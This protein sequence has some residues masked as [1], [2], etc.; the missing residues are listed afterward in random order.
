[1]TTPYPVP[2]PPSRGFWTKRTFS[3]GR[4]YGALIPN[5]KRHGV[6][7]LAELEYG[8][9]HLSLVA[10][11][12]RV[13]SF[14]FYR[15]CVECRLRTAAPRGMKL[16]IE[17]P[18][19]FAPHDGVPIDPEFDARMVVWAPA[20]V[21]RAVLE[22]PVRSQLL[23]MGT[24]FQGLY[25]EDGYVDLVWREPL[26]KPDQTLPGEGELQITTLIAKRLRDV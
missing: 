4:R 14:M 24:T 1:M 13:Y 16:S 2:P 8:G 15:K 5:A 12:M 26:P 18:G 3:L 19:L 21:A 11:P 17:R 6:G 7:L 10:H 23:A 25:V 20:D 9:S 22:A